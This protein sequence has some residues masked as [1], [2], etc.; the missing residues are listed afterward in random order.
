MKNAMQTG[1]PKAV[2]NKKKI[3]A[4]VRD[5]AEI[6]EREFLLRKAAEEMTLEAKM[7]KYC[8]D[9]QL[10]KQQS[11]L[12][13]VIQTYEKHR[14]NFFEIC[15]TDSEEFIMPQAPS[16][17]EH[18][19]LYSSLDVSDNP[20]DFSFSASF[21]DRFFFFMP[22][23]IFSFLFLGSAFIAGSYSILSRYFFDGDSL[24]LSL[25]IL[26][27]L[28]AL[29][30]Y[31][32]IIFTR[33]KKEA[34]RHSW[35][36]KEYERKYR[37]KQIADA[38]DKELHTYNQ[39]FQ[40]YQRF[41]ESQKNLAHFKSQT[42][43]TM[44]Q[45]TAEYRV[46]HL[47]QIQAHDLLVKADIIAKKKK[48]LY[49]LGIIPPDYRTLDACIMLNSIFKN[50]LA[51]TM[52]EAIL[53]YEERV[54]RGEVL[55]GIEKIYQMLGQLAHSMK[56]IE[57]RLTSIKHSVDSI[58]EETRTISSQLYN[59][60]KI[61]QESTRQIADEIQSAAQSN[62]Q[63]QAELLSQTQAAKQSAEA[64]QRTGQKYEWYMEQHRQG[65]I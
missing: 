37:Q 59:L 13:K 4:Y 56:A 43:S 6:E 27:P 47:F 35:R 19:E 51:D 1:Q 10:K 26:P 3:A 64:I 31:P 22:I 12:E 34:K 32:F 44:N 46:A 2:A 41:K 42:Q 53:L 11:H 61:T 18:Y 48:Q 65:L 49:Q 58:V 33:T 23:A 55:Q 9:S 8:F 40:A 5:M 36:K 62:E 52:R 63:Y 20:G 28:I 30:V 45:Q 57:D 54:Y 24:P 21:W 25:Y 7:S 17:P 39:Q 50:D 60:E 38:Y 15:N 16:M 14:Q 29:S